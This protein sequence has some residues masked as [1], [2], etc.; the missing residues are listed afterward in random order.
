MLDHIVVLFWV[1]EKHSYYFPQRLY[2]FTFLPTVY[3]GS[4]FPTFLPTFVICGLFDD[5]HSDRCKVIT[6]CDFDLHFS[7]DW[8]CWASFY[9][10]VQHL[11]FL[12]GKMSICFFHPFFNNSFFLCWVVW[13]F[14]IC[15]ILI[16]YQSYHLQICFSN[17]LVVFS[18]C[19]WFPLLC[20]SF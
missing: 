2:Q 16:P 19:Q 1:F 15:W 10:S 4:L 20:K 3:K 5:S 8:W 18:F 12:F 13:A 9:V 17:Q 7:S 6:Y 14:Y 11:H